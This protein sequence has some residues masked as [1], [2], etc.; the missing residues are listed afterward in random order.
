MEKVNKLDGKV[1]VI[2]GGNSGIGFEIAKLFKDEGA[3]V[4]ITGKNQE[5]V[6]AAAKELGVIGIKS[7]VSVLDDITSLYKEVKEIYDNIDILV[8][9][10]GISPFVPIEHSNE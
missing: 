7:D 5:K 10:A 3:K 9:T 2:T 4:I 1:A 8:L 6:A